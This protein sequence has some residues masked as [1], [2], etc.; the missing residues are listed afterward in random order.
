MWSKEEVI[1]ESVIVR[2]S[3]REKFMEEGE[4]RALTYLFATRNPE[5]KEDGKGIV[6]VPSL[7]GFG[8]DER[9][10]YAYQLRYVARECGATGIIFASEV[11]MVDPSYQAGLSKEEARQEMRKYKSLE[12]HPKRVEG[13]W[14]SLEHHRLSG[15]LTWF[16]PITRD[17]EGKPSL[18]DW[19]EQI[20]SEGEGRFFGMLPP[21][22]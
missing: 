7:G 20:W 5:T 16:A 6:L 2:T 22:N 18:Q 19:S 9:D 15:H 21:V 10:V 3:L 13:I 12:D 1:E 8:P 17:P 11:W 14:V 4:L